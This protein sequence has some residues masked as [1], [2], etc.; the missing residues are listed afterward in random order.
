MAAFEGDV[1]QVRIHR[2]GRAA[3]FV[4][5]VDRYAGLLGISH[6]LLARQQIPFAPRRD[7]LDVR[8]QRIGAQFEAHL[9][10]ALAGRAVRDGL[11]AGLVGDL[12]QTFGD[13]RARDR[14]AEQVFAFIHGVGAEHREHEI[15][16]EFFAQVVDE[17]VFRLDAHFQRL[18][19]RRFQLLSLAEV[20][21]EG[22]HFAMIGVLQPFQDDRGV[23]SAGIGEYGFFDVRHVLSTEL[24]NQ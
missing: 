22:D 4:F 18:G 20:G 3:F 6:Q 8:V 19:A 23:E 2:I 21:G 11:C 17:N 9:V 5:H 13:Q 10:V 7:D 15:A 16:H 24:I 12:N 1:Q 14:G